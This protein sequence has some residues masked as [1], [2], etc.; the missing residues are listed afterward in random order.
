MFKKAQL[1]FRSFLPLEYFI[2]NKI[3]DTPL[4][5]VLNQFKLNEKNVKP[6]RS[7]R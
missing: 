1:F 2:D 7:R 6:E 4:I 5:T 3:L